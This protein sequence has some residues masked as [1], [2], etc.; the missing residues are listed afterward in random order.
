MCQEFPREWPIKLFLFTKFFLWIEANKI[1]SRVTMLGSLN[2]MTLLW[3]AQLEDRKPHFLCLWDRKWK[4]VT[5]ALLSI[6]NGKKR[7]KGRKTLIIIILIKK[8]KKLLWAF[9]YMMLLNMRLINFCI[10]LN[11]LVRILVIHFLNI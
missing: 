8:S 1:I 2:A 7:E 6:T 10:S 5:L 3:L 9:K 4:V 11:E